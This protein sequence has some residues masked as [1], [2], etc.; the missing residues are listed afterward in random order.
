LSL[1]NAIL[2]TVSLWIV[3][4]APPTL[5]KWNLTGAHHISLP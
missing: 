4:L 1:T 2:L 5:G 3:L